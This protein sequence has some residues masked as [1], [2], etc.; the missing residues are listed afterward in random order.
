L[1]EDEAAAEMLKIFNEAIEVGIMCPF[2]GQVVTYI[3]EDPPQGTL[4]LDGST[5][6]KSDYPDLYDVLPPSMKSATSF[7]LP[8]MRERVPR[9]VGG[10]YNIGDTGGQDTVALSES[11]MPAHTH[12]ESIAVSSAAD[13]GTGVP[14]ASAVSG[15][16]TT[17]V[18]GSGMPHDNLPAFVAVGVAVVH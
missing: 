7:T 14:I 5:Y 8:D 10:T 16:G 4:A 9:F 1:T 15:V 11:E 17:G 6:D 2:V 13:A 3:S 12:T 18:A